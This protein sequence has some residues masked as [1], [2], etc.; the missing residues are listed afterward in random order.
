MFETES[1]KYHE[2]N[3]VRNN[4]HPAQQH[5]LITVC[6]GPILVFSDAQR[7]CSGV[8]RQDPPTRKCVLLWHLVGFR[9]LVQLVP[10]ERLAVAI[11]F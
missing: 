10:Q 11:T 1:I 5:V 4:V 9:V 3:H 8:G 6:I 2:L 7:C